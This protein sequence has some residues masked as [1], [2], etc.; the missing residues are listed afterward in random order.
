MGESHFRQAYFPLRPL[1]NCLTEPIGPSNNKDQLF[2][3]TV[4][5]LLEETG[6][7]NR[8][9]LPALFIQQENCITIPEA[10]QD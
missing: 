7:F 4:H 5:L 1:M 2:A 6:E 8:T 10:I 3:P 9:K